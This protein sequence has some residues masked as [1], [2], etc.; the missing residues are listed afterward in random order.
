MKTIREKVESVYSILNDLNTKG[1]APLID[2]AFPKKDGVADNEVISEMMLLR[3]SLNSIVKASELGIK[4]LSEVIK[5]A[6]KQ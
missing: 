2:A 1:R 6:E 3:E 4:N 5:M